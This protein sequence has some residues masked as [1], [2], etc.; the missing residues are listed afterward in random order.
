[1]VMPASAI[2]QPGLDGADFV[3]AGR[4]GEEL[5]EAL[6]AGVVGRVSVVLLGNVFASVVGVPKLDEG[7][8]D[9]R[10][11]AGEDAFGQISDFADGLGQT[12]VD[13]DQIVVLFGRH[14]CRRR[15]LS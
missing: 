14:G 10:A 1:M 4:A 3:G 8:S 15:V 12:V 11:A 6:E 5:A 7:A 9:G 13:I 2:V